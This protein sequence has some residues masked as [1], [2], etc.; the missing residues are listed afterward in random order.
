MS[1]RR[2]IQYRARQRNADGIL[3][4][5]YC[6][7]VV[8]KPPR[9]TFCSKECVDEYLVRSSVRFARQQLW[10][11]DKGVCAMCGTDTDAL[12][13]VLCCI[14]YRDP[15]GA[16][17][18]AWL[19]GYGNAFRRATARHNCSERYPHRVQHGTLWE[20][21]HILEVARGGG[22][23]GLEGLQTLCRPCHLRKTKRFA[24]HRASERKQK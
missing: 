17:Q 12:A 16:H 8:P 15:I 3:L 14:W 11:R 22:E 23:C 9:R 7:V 10:K 21:D 13:R 18:N 4:C 2:T 1:L 5:R 19:F 6:A 20:A 24:Q